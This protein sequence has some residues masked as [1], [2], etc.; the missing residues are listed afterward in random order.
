MTN[1]INSKQNTSFHVRKVEQP[2]FI[3]FS[4]NLI[5]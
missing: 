4:K 5:N 3:N 2:I 1:S